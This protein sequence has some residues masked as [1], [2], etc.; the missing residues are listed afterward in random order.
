MAFP[1]WLRGKGC[2]SWHENAAKRLSL[3][4]SIVLPV[5]A[6]RPEKAAGIFK[7]RKETYLT[8]QTDYHTSL[9]AVKDFFKGNVSTVIHH[10]F[11]PGFG[12]FGVGR[13][14]EG[15]LIPGPLPHA[16]GVRFQ[17]VTLVGLEK[18]A[19]WHDRVLIEF[20]LHNKKEPAVESLRPAGSNI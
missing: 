12:G 20:V 19:N 8:M 17:I 4:A 1:K 13:I 2:G 14:T 15:T 5:S 11:N 7:K 18:R 6:R 9:P 10:P 3:T 16:D